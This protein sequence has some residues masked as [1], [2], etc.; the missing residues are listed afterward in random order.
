LRDGAI[1][2]RDPLGAA[3]RSIGNELM[4]GK[5]IEE[6]EGWPARIAAVTVAVVN[7]AARAVLQERRSVTG[8][9]LPEARP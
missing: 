4:T 3:P 9:L 7:A 2:A 8:L 6:G 1:L 5:S